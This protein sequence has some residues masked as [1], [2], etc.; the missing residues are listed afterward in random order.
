MAD[1]ASSCDATDCAPPCFLGYC[2]PHTYTPPTVEPAAPAAPPTGARFKR[3]HV[4]V[5]HRPC[6]AKVEYQSGK[7]WPRAELE[8]RWEVRVRGYAQIEGLGQVD[9][10]KRCGYRISEAWYGV[11]YRDGRAWAMTKWEA[12][13]LVSQR[14]GYAIG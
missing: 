11:A 3:H 8:A 14:R 12:R 9:V 13:Q 1:D 7:A 6:V 5:D 4:F 10:Y 2:G